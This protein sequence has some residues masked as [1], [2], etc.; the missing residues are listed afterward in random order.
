MVG[1]CGVLAVLL[2]SMPTQAMAPLAAPMSG[3]GPAV[4]AAVEPTTT[5]QPM[6]FGA[7][8]PILRP[9]MRQSV[10]MGYSTNGTNSVSGSLYT[11]EM[12]WRLSEPLTFHLDLGVA[13][14]L[15]ASGPGSE[16]LREQTPV[17]LP[18]VGLEW[19][20]SDNTAFTLSLS[21]SPYA[22]SWNNPWASTIP[23]YGRP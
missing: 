18:T 16:A 7:P 12:S 13:T 1:S 17:L 20:P 21:R 15:W 22:S 3:F 8:S 19:R 4:P 11:N 10:T 5:F 6:G 23:G 2:G 14:P 9:K